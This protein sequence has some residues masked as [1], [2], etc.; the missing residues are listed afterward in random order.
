MDLQSLLSFPSL[1]TPTTPAEGTPSIYA[2]QE[3]WKAFRAKQAADTIAASRVANAATDVRTLDNQIASN[4]LDAAMLELGK[5]VPTPSYYAG[6]DSSSVSAD[7]VAAAG[8]GRGIVNPANVNPDA[9]APNTVQGQG[10]IDAAFPEVFRK[11]PPTGVVNTNGG[12][13]RVN[14]RTSEH[15]VTAVIGADGKITMTNINP[16]GSVNK[17]TGSPNS[18]LGDGKGNRPAIVAPNTP[19]A[20]N[21]ALVRLQTATPDEARG[22]MADITTSIAQAQATLEGEAL[23]FGANKFGIPALEQQ[24]VQTQA[25]DRQ[26]IGWYPGIGDSPITQKVRA[27]LEQANVAARQAAGEYMKTNVNFAA[28][29]AAKEN[30][31]AVFKRIERIDI[32]NVETN[33]RL[34]AVSAQKKLDKAEMDAEV[35]ANLSPDAL[36][37]I[38]I[39]HPVSKGN[40]T[41]AGDWYQQR[42]KATKGEIDKVLNAS[43]SGLVIYAMERNPEALAILAAEERKSDPT[44]TPEKIDIRLNKIK[45]LAESPNFAKEAAKFKASGLQGDARKQAEASFRSTIT[46]GSTGL[47]GDK[48]EAQRQRFEIALEMER[49]SQTTAVINDM[50]KLFSAEGPMGA[51]LAEAAKTTNSTSLENVMIAFVGSGNREERIARAMMFTNFAE[52]EILKH[53]NSVFGIPDIN[54][55]KAAAVETAIAHNRLSRIVDN[56]GDALTYVPK[57]ALQ[58]SPQ[59]YLYRTARDYLTE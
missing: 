17:G 45:Q 2:S 16:D 7:A 48:K 27:Q 53:G 21:A 56:V 59:G 10:F 29:N 55:I 22:L 25:A 13:D 6:G 35:A 31:T 20:I 11:Q 3:E 41:E 40:A 57:K 28:L 46:A 42:F 37:R 47:S 26:S 1:G 38:A 51:A 19:L 52:Q 36:N 43:S 24:L 33:S 32:A 9:P 5:Q 18:V 44:Q 54:A 34:A 58:Y 23:K 39:L 14:A 4:Q 12:V 50:S 49:A 8:A 30:A 15:G